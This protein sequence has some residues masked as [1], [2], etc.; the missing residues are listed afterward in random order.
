MYVAKKQPA[1]I[2]LTIQNIEVS[3][4]NTTC[5]TVNFST[6]ITRS[7]LVLKFAYSRFQ[8][9]NG[10]LCWFY[11][12]GYPWKSCPLAGLISTFRKLFWKIFKS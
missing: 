3:E 11:T 4:P 12:F 10:F 8:N 2:V 5:K 7:F 1:L 9:L 6:S